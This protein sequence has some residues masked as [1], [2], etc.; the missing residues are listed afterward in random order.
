MGASGIEGFENR[1]RLAAEHAPPQASIRSRPSPGAA[2]PA[3]MPD[4]KN[5]LRFDNWL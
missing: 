5:L 2:T 3:A 4:H 1:W